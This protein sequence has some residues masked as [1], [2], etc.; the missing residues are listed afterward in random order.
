[1]PKKRYAK[2]ARPSGSR[3]SMILSRGSLAC[4]LFQQ[5]TTVRAQI[6]GIVARA[7]FF[8]RKSV[9]FCFHFRFFENLLE[10]S[11]KGKCQKHIVDDLTRP[12]QRPGEFKPQKVVGQSCREKVS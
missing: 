4:T 8:S 10:K 7:R 9:S 11:G 6:P 1:M 12:G 5:E 3:T 2:S